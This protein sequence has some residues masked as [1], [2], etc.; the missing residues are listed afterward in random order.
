MKYVVY[1]C[2]LLLG[3]LA[4]RQ[5][6]ER[7]TASSLGYHSVDNNSLNIRNNASETLS[8]TLEFYEMS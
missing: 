7:K 1:G 2:V 6:Q 8:V 5:S 4:C 3:L